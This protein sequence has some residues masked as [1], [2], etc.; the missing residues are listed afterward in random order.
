MTHYRKLTFGESS[1][2]FAVGFWSIQALKSSDGTSTFFSGPGIEDSKTIYNTIVFG[3][4][5]FFSSIY[6]NLG[7]TNTIH[8]LFLMLIC[9]SLTKGKLLYIWILFTHLITKQH[10]MS[11]E[12][13]IF[14][15]LWKREIIIKSKTHFLKHWNW[16]A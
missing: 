11:P 15:F 4:V 2:A 5:F 10:L 7:N 8:P 3:N 1:S 13:N 12:V 14:S 6:L 9:Q 16:T